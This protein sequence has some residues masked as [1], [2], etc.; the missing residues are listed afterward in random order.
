MKRDRSRPRP[1]H[2]AA[3]DFLRVIC[4]F[5]IGWYH[6]WQQSWLT[7]RLTLGRLA[8]DVY[9]WVRAGYMFVD[10][11]L[12]L[13]GFLTYLPWARGKGPTALQFYRRR[14]VRILPCYWL[15]LLGMLLAA[16]LAPGF[17]RPGLLA[18]DLGTHLAFIHNLFRFSHTQTR[19]NGVLWTLAVEVQFYLLLPALAPAFRRM[20][21]LCWGAM[22]GAALCFRG[23]WTAPMADTTLFVNRLPN[24]L[25]VYANGMLAAHLYARL[26]G[27]KRC[28]KAVAALGTLLALLGAWGVLAVI[29]AQGVSYGDYEA[30]RHGQLDRRW[31]LS[32]AG[33]A[34]LL[35]GSLSFAPV[36]AA[37]SN[38]AVRFFCGISYN[39]YMW[40]QW[41]AVKLKQWRLPPYQSPANPNQAG[42]MPWQLHYTLACFAAALA[43]AILL[44]YL[45]EKP[46]AR[47]LRGNE[48][49][50]GRCSVIDR[51]ASL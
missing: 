22:T 45:V 44:T 48:S 11:M 30:L 8:L 37:L 18:R 46:V 34:F 10:L 12:L 40:H 26:A 19:L 27:E 21:L 36:R 42:E 7:P 31:L 24:M 35:G 51:S 4:A 13:S 1:D 6:I 3:A 5:M 9:P 39:F 50:R 49:I 17:D 43:L 33:A 25:D 47:R 14:A 23:L 28:R 2:A 41:L 29:R 16:V 32:A 38:R 15:A 20:P